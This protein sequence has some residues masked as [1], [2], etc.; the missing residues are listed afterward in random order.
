M[1]A[2]TRTISASSAIQTKRTILDLG[3]F[4]TDLLQ[5]ISTPLFTLLDAANITRHPRSPIPMVPPDP[6][7]ERLRLAEA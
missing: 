1:P 2:I 7:L 6:H 3:H 4:P 5:D